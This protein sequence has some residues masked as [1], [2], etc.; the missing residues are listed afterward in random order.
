MRIRTVVISLACAMGLLVSGCSGGIPGVPQIEGAAAVASTAGSNGS[1][2]GSNSTDGATES[3]TSSS[4]G[5]SSSA[6]SDNGNGSSSDSGD[7]GDT[8]LPSASSDSP[9]LPSGIGTLPTDLGSIPGV[10]SSCLSVAGIL[11]SVGV[12]FLAPTLGGKPLTKDQ[13]DQA[14]A[15]IGE[16][17]PELKQPVQ[18]LHDAALQAVGKSA[19][20]AAAIVGSDTVNQAMD[21][22]SKYTDTKCGGS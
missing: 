1:G 14:F 6:G 18:V 13:V 12:L 21:A 9:S 4:A 16:V 15:G 8:G 22:L 10:D 11:M 17:P 5:G 7:G 2:D 3:S 20:E 19:T